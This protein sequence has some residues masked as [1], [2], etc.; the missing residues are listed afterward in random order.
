MVSLSP[1][2]EPIYAEHSPRVQD[3][4]SSPLCCSFLVT[5]SNLSTQTSPYQM[6]TWISA[7][8]ARTAVLLLS[9]PPSPPPSP[10][11]VLIWLPWMKDGDTLYTA[12]AD[13]QGKEGVSQGGF[14]CEERWFSQS[15]CNASLSLNP[16]AG[17]PTGFA[18]HFAELLSP[19]PM[20]GPVSK[21]RWT[22]S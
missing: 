18:H 17:R 16:R 8:L 22:V 12:D 11:N 5:V 2:G 9:P 14:C 19:G 20:R 3:R 6:G 15:V 10:L 21:T 1:L 13:S 7:G 4:T